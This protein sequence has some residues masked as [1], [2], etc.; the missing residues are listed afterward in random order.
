MRV[1]GGEDLG[2]G[3][4]GDFEEGFEDLIVR[5]VGGT[6]GYRVR[7]ELSRGKAILVA[8]RRCPRLCRCS[9]LMFLVCGGVESSRR[10]K[11]G[12]RCAGFLSCNKVAGVF[13]VSQAVHEW[14]RRA[15]W[16]I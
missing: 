10:R 16:Q 9:A 3:A 4:L 8:I 12:C 13:D 1:C 11:Y 14:R 15:F 6:H 5:D 2:A 7:K